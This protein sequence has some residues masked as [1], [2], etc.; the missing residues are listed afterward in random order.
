MSKARRDLG[1]GSSLPIAGKGNPGLQKPVDRFLLCVTHND[2]SS[3][4]RSTQPTSTRPRDFILEF[5]NGNTSGAV[6]NFPEWCSP[7]NLIMMGCPAP[8]SKKRGQLISNRN[9]WSHGHPFSPCKLIFSSLCYKEEE[10]TQHALL[11]YLES[12]ERRWKILSSLSPNSFGY[13]WVLMI[14]FP[15]PLL[16]RVNH[17]C[18]LIRYILES[19]VIALLLNQKLSPSKLLFFQWHS[20]L[21]RE[22][23]AM[24]INCL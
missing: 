2:T 23:K 1:K 22:E 19:E 8:S 18:S 12:W 3:A 6:W 9:F 15:L 11:F 17:V 16:S 7:K 21:L 14:L 5:R 13:L 4:G 24:E 20:S 10:L